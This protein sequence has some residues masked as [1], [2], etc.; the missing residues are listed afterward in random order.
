LHDAMISSGC[1]AWPEEE[2]T[3]CDLSSPTPVEGGGNVDGKVLYVYGRV[4]ALG[5][6]TNGDTVKGTCARRG[7]VPGCVSGDKYRGEASA[8]G[9]RA[10]CCFVSKQACKRP[11]IA[12]PLIPTSRKLSINWLVSRRGVLER[13]RGV[14]Q[15]QAANT[16]RGLRCM[17]PAQL[18]GFPSWLL[19]HEI[20]GSRVDSLAAAHIS[21]GLRGRCLMFWQEDP[22][23]PCPLPLLLRQRPP[24]SRTSIPHAKL[25]L[26]A[27]QAC[28]R[29]RQP[30]QSKSPPRRLS[31]PY[32]PQTARATT[33]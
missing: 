5:R 11:R 32:A 23:F 24:N 26:A 16:G 7:C 33:T 27:S 6:D 17:L 15:Y 3:Y 10:S 4:V 31:Q 22:S 25:S 30:P 12:P 19:S 21:G 1:A 2:T 18:I 8:Y 14:V 9:C 20:P 13:T 29:L 28:R